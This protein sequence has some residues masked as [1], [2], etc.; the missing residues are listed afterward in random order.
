ML[1]TTALVPG[2]VWRHVRDLAEGLP[3]V[4][5]QATIALDT[6]A[7]ALRA[8]ATAAGLEVGDLGAVPAGALLHVH[9]ADTFDR[10]ATA[11]MRRHRRAGPVV[12]TEHLPRTNA[13]DA[14]L[15]PGDRRTP[16]AGVA[17]TL[18]KRLQYAAADRVV[19]VGVSSGA[20]IARRWRLPASRIAVVHN[21]LPPE[22]HAPL[23]PAEGRRLVVIGTLNVQKGQDVL[24]EALRRARTPWQAT[25][26]G[27]GP[28]RLEY[29]RLAAGL[30]VRFAGW[31]DD[32]AAV[33]TGCSLVCMPS[34]WESFPYAALEAGL[35]ARPLLAARVDGP[36]EIVEDGVTG[37]LVPPE[38]PTPLAAALD[39]LAED[40][41]GLGAMG[42][43]ARERVA[44]RYTLRAML[45]ETAE[46]Y[47][48]VTSER[49]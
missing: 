30:P 45:R 49:R 11:V 31:Q 47:A 13:S 15:L 38:D 36:D 8:E 17:K 35:W 21:G 29:E 28:Q 9:L 24:I 26:V 37:V 10:E 23:P 6:R 16:G 19:A 46:V 5:W 12:L 2:G 41:D 48:H 25:L 32:P 3:A 14:S 22:R 7:H 42:A 34:R 18:F 4:G 44:T 33:V 39:R 1:A 43:R 40:S 20:F 27:E